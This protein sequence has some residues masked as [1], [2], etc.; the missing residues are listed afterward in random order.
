M[1]LKAFFI[2]ILAMLMLFTACANDTSNSD[3]PEGMQLFSNENV[4]YTAYVPSDWTVDMSTGTL[5]AYVSSV[6][7][8]NVTIT[9][10]ILENTTMSL[11]EY[12]EGY[13]EDFKETFSDMKYEGEVPTTTTL[14]SLPANKYV[15]TATVTGNE[16]KF[17]QV[18]C[19]TK[20]KVYVITYTSTP[21]M[22]DENIEDVEKILDTFTFNS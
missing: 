9:G 8:S 2:S 6:D 5:S 16:Y 10:A 3:I 11:D 20:A 12:W 1:K 15:Y 13:A 4:D 17:M 19:I 22:Y 14:D 18:V 7:A 21:D